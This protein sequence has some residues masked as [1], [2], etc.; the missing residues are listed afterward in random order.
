MAALGCGGRH[1]DQVP[2]RC[3]LDAQ[4]A[5]ASAELEQLIVGESKRLTHL[6]AQRHFDAANRDLRHPKSA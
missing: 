2:L 4:L 1:H 3:A 6:E 5:V